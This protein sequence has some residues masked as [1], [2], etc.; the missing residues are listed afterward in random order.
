MALDLFHGSIPGQSLTKPMGAMPHD[1]PPQYANLDDA[2]TY[3]FQVLTS[4]RQVTRLVIMLRKGVPVEYIARSIIFTGFGKGKWTPDV[5]LMMLK[6]TMAM[7]ISIAHIKKVKHVIFSPDKEQNDFLDQF[8]DD[9]QPPD[10]DA[11]SQP[12]TGGAPAA[13]QFKGLLG[14]KL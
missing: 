7:I 1:N 12:A 6:T 4:P 14:G 2:L 9:V 5:G 13:P 8:G 3:M 10:P 11:T